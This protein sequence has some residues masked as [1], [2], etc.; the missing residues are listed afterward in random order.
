MTLVLGGTPVSRGILIAPAVV[1][2]RDRLDVREV[3]IPPEAVAGEVSRYEKALRETH[4]QLRAIRKRIPSQT[5]DEI[6]AFID[7]HLLMLADK[8]LSDVPVKTI[9]E[10]H[11]NAE[12]ALQLQ[13]DGLVAVF[14][15]M[16]DPYLR[17]RRDDVDYVVHK[18]LQNLLNISGNQYKDPDGRLASCILITDDISAEEV[19]TFHGMGVAG[20]ITEQGGAHSHAAILARSLGIPVVAG[21]HW[22]RRYLRDGDTIVLD[23]LRGLILASPSEVELDYF[24]RRQSEIVDYVRRLDVVRSA[25]ALSMDGC[26]IRLMANVELPEDIQ[27]AEEVNAEGIGLYRTEILYLQQTS[28]P[29]E[30]FQYL[31]YKD[32]ARIL[33]GKPLTIRTLDLGGDKCLR[34]N[35]EA[36]ANKCNP[37]LGLRAVRLSLREQDAFAHQLR[38]IL[39]VSAEGPVRLMLPMLTSLEELFRIKTLLDEQ[40]QILRARGVPFDEH[41]Q[42]GGMI[43]V[44]AAAII[45]DQFARHLDFLSIGTNDLVQYTLAVDRMDEDVDYLYNPLHP[46]VLRLLKMTIDAGR[47]AGIPVA[48]CGEIAGDTRF[49]RLLLGLGLREFSMYPATLLEVKDVIAHS[50]IAHL[51]QRL[52]VLD[53][54]ATAEEV[55]SFVA[56]LNAES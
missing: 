26:T 19:M 17:T 56:S 1:L 21:A 24:R 48:M 43:E 49:T 12:W 6:A 18:I 11:C 3:R 15:A 20:L 5:P 33:N 14:D 55:L 45:A 51:E 10:Q 31:I 7:A 4:K 36:Q 22:A 40:R 50:D 23:G 44:P 37:A 35:E 34:D 53:Q 38:A 32:A 47:K 54:L 25:P 30:E 16:D 2:Q 13:R 9:T 42:V 27:A 29:E 28:V 41:M 46:S 8:A 39:R 52:Q